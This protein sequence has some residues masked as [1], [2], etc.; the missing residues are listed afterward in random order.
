MDRLNSFIKHLIDAIED[1][2]I[3]IQIYNDEN[4]GTEIRS[5]EYLLPMLANN[6][7]EY[8]KD[9]HPSLAN[10]LMYPVALCE[11]GDLLLRTTPKGLQ[12]YKENKKELYENIY[13]KSG[14]RR[15]YV[16]AVD[17]DEAWVQHEKDVIIKD[18]GQVPDFG[19]MPLNDTEDNMKE[20]ES[21]QEKEDETEELINQPLLTLEDLVNSIPEALV[22]VK[23]SAVEINDIIQI[24][25]NRLLLMTFKNIDSALNERQQD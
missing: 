14:A 22:S 18:I 4:D 20:Q 15:V 16:Y 5:E 1:G 17:T 24:V 11:N 9:T 19:T 21:K 13:L 6:V 7:G 25:Q 12:Y 10:Q 2:R 3:S 8:I 23:L